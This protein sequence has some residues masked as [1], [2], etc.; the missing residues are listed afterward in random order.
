MKIGLTGGIGCGKSTAGTILQ[1]LGWRRIDTDALVRDLLD[2]DLQV[3]QA[4]CAHFGA[5]ALL[6]RAKTTPAGPPAQSVEAGAPPLQARHL[7]NR[8]FLAARIFSNPQ[9]RLWLESLL[10][11]LVRQRWEAMV[12][13]A[14]QSPVV[15]EIPL[16]FEK[17]L[18]K[19]F[20]LTVCVEADHHVQL[21]RL[22]SRT[23]SPAAAEA[24]IASQMP[25]AEKINRADKV[26]SNNGT[27]VFF[28]A[29]VLHLHHELLAQTTPSSSE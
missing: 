23:M 1:Q 29:Q 11:P 13:T 25:L 6:P 8:P 7:A 17:N 21:T 28:R 16:L 4:L 24:R 18:E 20:D 27:E 10:H 26:L 3:Q 22:Q 19:H 15:V 9:E 14:G 5:E 2:N 12:A